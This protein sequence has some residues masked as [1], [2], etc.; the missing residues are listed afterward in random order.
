LAE[1]Q[2]LAAIAR[3]VRQSLW[4]SHEFGPLE[5]DHRGL[6]PRT[7]EANNGLDEFHRPT[8]NHIATKGHRERPDVRAFIDGSPH[9]TDGRRNGQSGANH[10]NYQSHEF[11]H[12]QRRRP[13]LQELAAEATQLIRLSTRLATQFQKLRRGM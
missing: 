9:V 4:G 12:D 1:A 11:H 8:C 7:R 3:Q 10:P 13:T 6:T 5:Q 2:A